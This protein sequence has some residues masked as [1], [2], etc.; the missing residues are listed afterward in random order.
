MTENRDVYFCPILNCKGQINKSINACKSLFTKV[1]PKGL[2]HF[3]LNKSLKKVPDR[4]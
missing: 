2:M 1:T 4:V 3:F